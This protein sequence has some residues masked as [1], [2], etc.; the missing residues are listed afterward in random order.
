MT[1]E[2]SEDWAALMAAAQDGEARAYTALL[3][4]ITPYLR[5]VARR[6]G[7]EGDEIEDGVQDILLTIHAIRQSYDPRRP[8]APWLLAVARHRLI[9]RLRRRGRLRFRE[10]ELTPAHETFAMDETNLP[11]ES[12]EVRQLHKAIAGLPP[13]QR[14]AVEL[15]RLQELTLKEA[16]ARSGQSPSALKVAL[17]R[18]LRR[19]RTLMPRS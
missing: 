8:F 18:A 19:L 17:H 1:R 3:R 7:L 4:A 15:L 2:Q 11:D 14:Q 6:A 12:G 16:A 9:D 13:G 10:T 5:A